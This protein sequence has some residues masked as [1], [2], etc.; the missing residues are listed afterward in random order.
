MS[1]YD[2]ILGGITLIDSPRL[3]TFK[4]WH[5]AVNHGTKGGKLSQE[6]SYR[7][8]Q[9]VHENC[10]FYHHPTYFNDW[11]GRDEF[12][13]LIECV[14]EVFGNSFKWKTINIT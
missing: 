4:V 12:V 13:V 9:H 5:E 10:T 6:V 1:K 14:S 3:D 7:F 2:N 8:S 11:T